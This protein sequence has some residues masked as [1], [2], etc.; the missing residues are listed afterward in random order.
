MASKIR[1]GV[2]GGALIHENALKN[3]RKK[4]IKTDYGVCTLLEG[5][6]I[7]FIPRH[8]I[9]KKVPPH[10]INHRANIL[11]LKESDIEHALGVCSVGSLKKEFAPGLIAVPEDYVGFWD[12]PTFFESEIKHIT[13]SLD[14]HLRKIIASTASRLRFPVFDGGVYVQT[15]G[16]RLETKAE[17]KFLASLGDVVGMTMASEATLAQEAGLKYAGLCSV[18]NF[19]NGIVDEKLDFEKVIKKSKEKSEKII[20]LINAV[21]EELNR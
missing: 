8:G 21:A 9:Q 17:V 10:K 4:K 5:E 2:L 13:P 11:A 1:L 16:P 15:T 12:T 20:A 14:H 19:A 7:V 3:L 18:D 6:N